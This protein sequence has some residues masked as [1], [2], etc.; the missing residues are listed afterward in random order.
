MVPDVGDQEL[1][2]QDLRLLLDVVL[3]DVRMRRSAGGCGGGPAR[4]AG[5][6]EPFPDGA[7][8]RPG[9][10]GEDRRWHAAGD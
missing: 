4:A 9:Q 6:H 2:R 8:Q 7:G 3:L 1:V 5:E 10:C